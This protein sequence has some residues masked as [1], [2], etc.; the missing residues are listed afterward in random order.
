[1][2]AACTIVSIAAVQSQ[3]YRA[4]PLELDIAIRIIT[5]QAGT[6]AKTI[7][8]LPLNESIAAPQPEEL[9]YIHPSERVSLPVEQ[10]ATVAQDQLIRSFWDQSEWKLSIQGHWMKW[11]WAS[12]RWTITFF[13]SGDQGWASDSDEEDTGHLRL[14][15]EHTS[16]GVSA[17][18]SPWQ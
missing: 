11:S 9:H 18:S 2:F 12:R 7:D 16:T 1:M 13:I 8:Q 5:H 3:V 14:A 10:V 15:P 6:I 4:L 17:S